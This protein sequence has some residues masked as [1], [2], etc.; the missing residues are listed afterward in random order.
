M[1][2]VF[3]KSYI[4]AVETWYE[5]LSGRIF[6]FLPFLICKVVENVVRVHKISILLSYYFIFSPL[7]S[8]HL[9]RKDHLGN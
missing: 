7:L 9:A 2:D 4:Q 6:S 8:F 5:E 3:I 1:L